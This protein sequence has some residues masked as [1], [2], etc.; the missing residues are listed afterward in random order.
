MA[1]GN[2]GSYSEYTVPNVNTSVPKSNFEGKL[3]L[4]CL[5]SVCFWHFR[6]LKS[7]CLL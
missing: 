1:T 2:T 6:E 3:V 5:A 7:D 4:L